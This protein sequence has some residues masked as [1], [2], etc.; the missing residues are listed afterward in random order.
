LSG[1]AD[2]APPLV[3]R[4][5][6]PEAEPLELLRIP[7]PDRIELLPVDVRVVRDYGQQEQ[8]EHLQ[9]T[10][11]GQIAMFSRAS[12][13]RL[14]RVARNAR[15]GLVSQFC[16]T[17][18][19][20]AP[21]GETAKKHLRAWL[22]ALRESVPGAGYL[23]ILEFQSRGVPHFH[24]WLTVAFSETLWKLLGEAWNRIAEPSSPEH[25]WWHTQARLDPDTGKIQRSFMAWDMKGAGYLRKYMSKEAQKCAPGGFGWVGRFWGS[26]RSLVPPIEVIEAH[27]LPDI[28][29][30]TRTLSKWVEARR[31]RGASVGRR[32][33]RDKGWKYKAVKLRPT[34]RA[35]PRSGWLNNAAPAFWKYLVYLEDG[36]PA[37][38]SFKAAFHV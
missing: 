10:K 24:V 29:D 22:Q 2:E 13:S 23:W 8:P 32:I 7:R 19:Q 18:H 12:A 30:I 25:L 33:A 9:N 36:K 38:S 5:I 16:L 20:T 11:R 27:E 26:S 37:S 34:V 21:D 35:Q 31:R 4:C 6:S 14:T 15:P 3:S 1:A 28:R 17:Y